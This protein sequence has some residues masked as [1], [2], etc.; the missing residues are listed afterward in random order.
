MF[1]ASLP[2]SGA[3]AWA[4]SS[5]ASR[6]HAPQLGLPPTAVLGPP[7]LLAPRDQPSLDPVPQD[8]GP[9]SWG[10]LWC[11]PPEPVW[12]L[13]PFCPWLCWELRPVQDPR[14]CQSPASALC[15]APPPAPPS[16][17]IIRPPCD[18]RTPAPAVV[19]EGG[20]AQARAGGVGLGVGPEPWHPATS[21]LLRRVWWAPA[22]DRL[23]GAG[24]CEPTG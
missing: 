23:W 14:S 10:D 5:S 2:L 7:G 9:S 21:A 22:P 15:A 1:L 12:G 8:Q 17:P 18:T 20:R 11:V 19:L 4:H 3:H 16:W 24:R 13:S 6:P